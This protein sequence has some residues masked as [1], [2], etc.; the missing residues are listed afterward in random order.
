MLVIAFA[1]IAFVANMSSLTSAFRLRCD[2]IKE[3]GQQFESK[4]RPNM[5]SNYAC[6]YHNKTDTSRASTNESKIWRAC[7]AI[8]TNYATVE[9]LR[10]K[11]RKNSWKLARLMRL[12]R[13]KRRPEVRTH[14]HTHTHTHTFACFACEI[15]KFS[16]ISVGFTLKY[17]SEC[18]VY[19]KHVCYC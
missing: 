3:V 10:H 19:R 12:L 9:C 7:E 5:K 1:L 6:V 4:I 11:F 18:T 17:F 15:Y 14:T 2:R 13:R 8:T 16:N